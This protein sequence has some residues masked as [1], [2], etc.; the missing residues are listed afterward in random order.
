MTGAC[1]PLREVIAGTAP[2]LYARSLIHLINTN[3][4]TARTRRFGRVRYQ[5][6]DPT[7]VVNARHY[8]RARVKSLDTR[9][10]PPDPAT[11][12]MCGL[13]RALWIEDTLNLELPADDLRARLDTITAHFTTTNPAP[14]LAAIPAV[15]TSVDAAIGDL[16]VS[17]YR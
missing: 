6:T 16:A 15:T 3:V 11:D 5:P 10:T 13:I 2:S 12:A 14:D 4:V 7:D 9:P 17:V 1:L 8:P